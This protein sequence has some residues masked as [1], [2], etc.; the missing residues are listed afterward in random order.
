MELDKYTLRKNSALFWFTSIIP[1]GIIA[2]GINFNTKPARS[3]G[4]LRNPHHRSK[5]FPLHVDQRHPRH[6]LRS[7]DTPF[8]VSRR[9]KID[10]D[11]IR[12]RHL[13]PAQRRPR[14]H[15][16]F[17][18]HRIT[19]DSLGY[20]F[21][22]DGGFVLSSAENGE[23]CGRPMSSEPQSAMALSYARAIC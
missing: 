23:S 13:H 7:G 8:S 3:I 20:S 6:F 2:I 21:L 10:L 14:D 17:R 11:P 15:R 5:Q 16:E 18:L 12:D 4:R 9:S 22:H 1:V 19:F